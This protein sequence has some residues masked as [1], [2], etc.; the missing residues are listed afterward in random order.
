MM[1]GLIRTDLDILWVSRFNYSSG[2]TVAPHRHPYEQIIL[3]ID[4]S[5]VLL[6]DEHE[7]AVSNQHFCCY[8]AERQH[9][10]RAETDMKTLDIK[11][12][13]TGNQLRQA[14]SRLPALSL[15]SNGQVRQS[16]ETI[17]Q[18]SSSEQTLSHERCCLALESCLL[19]L[20]SCEQNVTASQNAA[21]QSATAQKKNEWQSNESCLQA[22]MQVIQEHYHENLNTN[23]LQQKTGYTYRHLSARCQ[24]VWSTTPRA[25]IQKY[26]LARAEDLLRYSDYPV[27]AIAAAVG[28]HT[29]HHFTRCFSQTFGCGPAAYRK[30]ERDHLGQGITL[31]SGFQNINRVIDP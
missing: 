21:T 16:L 17:I 18:L 7:H 5:G 29:V 8:A 14:F 22:L 9:G 20:L 26:R 28:F 24:A 13:I 1:D 6:I 27:K 4:G 30:R 10:L 15:D 12:R 23:T 25:L 11:F 31:Q 3:I 19:E 2:Q